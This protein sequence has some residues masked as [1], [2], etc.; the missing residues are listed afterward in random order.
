MQYETQTTSLTIARIQN[1]KLWQSTIKDIAQTIEKYLAKLFQSA[2]A[3]VSYEFLYTYDLKS[4]AI[5]LKPGVAYYFTCFSRIINNLCQQ[6]WTDF[7]RKNV[8]N[9]PSFSYNVDLQQFLFHQS[10]QSL[11]LLESIL[12]DTQ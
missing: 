8:H 5:T 12:I 9:Q 10:R 4:N 11:K 3:K 1:T 6:Y 2:E 7:V